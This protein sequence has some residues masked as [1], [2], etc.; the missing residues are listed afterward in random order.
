MSNALTQPDLSAW[1]Q[2]LRWNKPSGRLILLIPAGW[3]LWLAPTAPPAPSLVTLIVLGGLAVSGAG[4]IANDLWD[5]RFD[6]EVTRTRHRPLAQGKLSLISAFA[7]LVL[8]LLLSL[9]IVLALP[10]S[11]RLRCLLLALLALPPILLYPSAK[12]WFA[13][14]QA[15]LAIC[16]GFAVLIPWAAS[17]ASLQ[18]SA[19]LFGCWLATLFWTFGFDTVYAMADRPDDA[20]LGLNSSA[21][22]LGHRAVLVV[23]FSYGLTSLC[24]ALAAWPA[25]LGWPFWLCW[26]TTTFGMQCAASDLRSDRAQPM[27]TFGLHF[28]RQ[29]WLG[30]LLLLGVILGRIG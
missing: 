11:T 12:R 10:D 5:R 9:M 29:V 20:R 22:S 2:L 7:G 27:A 18:P 16:W 3:S 4:C 28:Q 1:I 26:L 8:L 30:A 6:R 15:V 25:D 23:R 24:M 21:L 17:G 19:T 13:Y 14:P